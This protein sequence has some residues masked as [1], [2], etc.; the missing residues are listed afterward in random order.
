MRRNGNGNGNGRGTATEPVT[1]TTDSG[2]SWEFTELPFSLNDMLRAHW[3]KRGEIR[4][5]YAM[6]FRAGQRTAPQ[7]CELTITWRVTQAMDWDNA[8]ARFKCIG[9]AMVL[10]G[11][12]AD[13]NPDVVRAFHVKQQ[14]VKH[15]GEQGFTVEARAC[16]PTYVQVPQ[17][18][19]LR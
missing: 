11:V 16:L 5:Y 13:D 18:K 4:D 15:R 17:T 6:L 19:V 12:L 10:A 9:D 1:D 7:P 3:S 8:A 14:R 2:V